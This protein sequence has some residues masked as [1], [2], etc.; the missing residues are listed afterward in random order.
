MLKP[1]NVYSGDIRFRESVSGT[2]WHQIISQISKINE[3]YMP[4]SDKI[5][6]AIDRDLDEDR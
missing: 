2:V 4:V 6:S 5:R 3:F 1:V